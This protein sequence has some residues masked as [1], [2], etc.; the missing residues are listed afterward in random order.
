MTQRDSRPSPLQLAALGTPSIADLKSAIAMNAIAGLPV[1]TKDVDLAEK[2]FGPDLGTLKG[3]TTR[4]KPLPLVRDQ[5]SI[6]PELYEKRQ[7]LELCIDVMFVNGKPYLTSISKAL[8]YRMAIPLPGRKTEELL[9]TLDK[10]LCLYNSCYRIP[11]SI[12][13]RL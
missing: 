5:I 10:K 8:Y 12:C 4:K 2:I 3:K 6:P 1:T 13:F 11:R 7:S 9:D